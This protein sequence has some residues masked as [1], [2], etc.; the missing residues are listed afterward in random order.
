[1]VGLW[2][3][4]IAGGMSSFCPSLSLSS[5]WCWGRE[6]AEGQQVSLIPSVLRN[7]DCKLSPTVISQNHGEAGTV[8]CSKNYPFN[9]FLLIM[10]M[11]QGNL[12]DNIV[13]GFYALS[14]PLGS[15]HS[16]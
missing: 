3:T 9:S 16:S 1:M 11:F 6:Q 15:P 2:L 12:K 10:Q 7:W 8:K 14:L 4:D 5:V 13:T